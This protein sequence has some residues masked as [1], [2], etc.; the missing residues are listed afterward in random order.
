MAATKALILLLLFTIP[1]LAL[2]VT[3]TPNYIRTSP[4]REITINVEVN[5][6]SSGIHSISVDGPNISYKKSMELMSGQTR[7]LPISVSIAEPG[8]YSVLATVTAESEVQTASAQ[9]EVISVL[10][11]SSEINA[12]LYDLEQNL[13]KMEVQVNGMREDQGSKEKVAQIRELLSAANSSYLTGRIIDAR[14][15]LTEAEKKMIQVNLL[16][17]MAE[18]KE[19]SVNLGLLVAG[20]LVLIIGFVII[21]HRRQP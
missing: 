5:A 21:Q 2:S 3:L 17:K 6:T 20:L 16:I 10:G 9:I 19:T 11:S 4:S 13:I 8:S 18:E 14:E 7:S 1:A 15:K 12:T